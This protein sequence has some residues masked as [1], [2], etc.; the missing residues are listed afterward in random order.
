MIYLENLIGP[1]GLRFTDDHIYQ[2]FKSLN[3]DVL[4]REKFKKHV[5]VFCNDAKKTLD[6][7]RQIKGFSDIFE[8]D[9]DFLDNVTY[10]PFE[11]KAQAIVLRTKK[12]VIDRKTKSLLGQIRY[13]TRGIRGVEYDLADQKEQEY[14]LFKK[15]F[16]N[17][18]RWYAPSEIVGQVEKFVSPSKSKRDVLTLVDHAQYQTSDREL[19]EMRLE[20]LRKLLVLNTRD[21]EIISTG[22]LK[23]PEEDFI[24][25]ESYAD[26]LKNCIT[27]LRRDEGIKVD[28][29]S[30]ENCLSKEIEFTPLRVVDT[31]LERLNLMNRLESSGDIEVGHGTNICDFR[32]DYFKLIK[33]M[34]LTVEDAFNIPQTVINQPSLG[35]VSFKALK[36]GIKQDSIYLRKHMRTEQRSLEDILLNASAGKIQLPKMDSYARLNSLRNPNIIVDNQV[37]PKLLDDVLRSINH[38]SG[39]SKGHLKL[40]DFYLFDLELLLIPLRIAMHPENL[41]VDKMESL[42][43]HIYSYFNIPNRIFFRHSNQETS[44]APNKQTII[45]LMRYTNENL[46]RGMRLT[47]KWIYPYFSYV[48]QILHEKPDIA[49]VYCMS[50]IFQ[51][52]HEGGGFQEFSKPF[53]FFDPYK[54][55]ADC[56]SAHLIFGETVWT[57]SQIS[58]DILHDLKKTP[59]HGIDEI[60][61][62]ND[63]VLVYMNPFK[64]GGE[65]FLAGKESDVLDTIQRITEKYPRLLAAFNS[66]EDHM[67]VLDKNHLLATESGS[68]V[69][70]IGWSMKSNFDPPV[71][72]EFI[73]GISEAL[74]KKNREEVRELALEELR[75]IVEIKYDP[76]LYR[77]QHALTKSIGKY[78]TGNFR[79]MTYLKAIKEMHGDSYSP[80]DLV[81]FYI[82]SDGF[83]PTVEGSEIDGWA[84]SDYIFN[85]AK[86]LLD[87]LGIKEFPKSSALP[88]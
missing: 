2:Y 19:L 28:K 14:L 70:T 51:L 67:V 45:S 35:V 79:T 62:K 80:R 64:G 83:R 46:E 56:C 61:R 27:V 84:Y 72:R 63:A 66:A 85:S 21:K 60:A 75:N 30:L 6:E 47:G 10:T 48:P 41:F 33:P 40:S 74:L 88:S 18:L 77:F 32:Y 49:P 69:R 5:V 7:I 68:W 39:D 16:G 34:G 4:V 71:V 53:S 26:S 9:A 31:D 25:L 13:K 12:P 50:P 44:N 37:N 57:N 22:L 20:G 81:K 65:A 87:S 3:G 86:I 8:E 38:S 11:E 43:K 54:F 73:K 1:C 55:M 78:W 17:E 58:N 59:L 82:T 52:I 76:R 36:P 42:G 23:G 24:V 29:K 15:L